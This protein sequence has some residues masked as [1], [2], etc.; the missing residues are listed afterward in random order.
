M[1]ITTF[2]CVAP[3]CRIFRSGQSAHTTSAVALG[4][5]TTYCPGPHSSHGSQAPAFTVVEKL[6][7]A[8]G[9]Q[10]RSLLAVGAAAS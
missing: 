7:S 1:A 6:P 5:V 2:G 4:G 9:A 8:H 3:S 10:I